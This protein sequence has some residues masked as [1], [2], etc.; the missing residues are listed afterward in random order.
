M[1]DYM[2]NRSKEKKNKLREGLTWQTEADSELHSSEWFGAIIRYFWHLGRRE[3]NTFY[4]PKELKK[5]TII[6][7]ICK[8]IMLILLMYIVYRYSTV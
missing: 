2:E 6:G 4:N 3:F 1:Y 8:M 7:W 5:N